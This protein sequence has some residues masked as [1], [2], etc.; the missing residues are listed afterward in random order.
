MSG[1]GGYVRLKSVYS[2]LYVGVN[3]A[4]TAQIIQTATQ[5]DYTLWRAALTSA[6]NVKLTCKATNDVL[7]VPLN[8]NDNGTDLTQL[9]Y[10]N[11]TNYRDEW[12]LHYGEIS[13]VN[14]YD[15]TF[16]SDLINKITPANM[17]VYSAFAD[18]FNLNMSMDGISS[19]TSPADNCPNNVNDNPSLS[20]PCTEE[21]CGQDCFEHHKSILRI[22][23]E[24]YNDESREEDH[25][26]V[27]WSD[28]EN[29]VY[30]IYENGEHTVVNAIAAVVNY[31][32]IIQFFT[33]LDYIP[34]DVGPP[35]YLLPEEQEQLELAC[36][37]IGLAHEM[38]HTFG[39]EEMYLNDEHGGVTEPIC[40]MEIFH[41]NSAI[42]YYSDILN[43]ER[44]PFCASCQVRLNEL[45]SEMYSFG[46]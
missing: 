41:A 3:S 9:D 26:Y 19:Y 28:Y 34:I 1:S 23:S 45:I 42:E 31:S 29:P 36:M 2:G 40:V 46:N 14:Y 13:F 17:F 11:D 16:G 12:G 43:G 15:S 5:D 37:A 38:A 20:G 27:L 35:V 25:I 8:E 18:C 10:T 7:A 24:L 39:L 21:A 22:N 4:N 33:V 30:C 32:P 44:E 6:E